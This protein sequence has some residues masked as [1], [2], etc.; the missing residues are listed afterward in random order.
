MKEF[1]FVIAHYTHSKLLL[2]RE[3][4]ALT[5]CFLVWIDNKS[6]MD[7]CIENLK[8]KV[9][10]K[11]QHHLWRINKQANKNDEYKY[12]VESTEEE[13]TPYNSNLQ[14]QGIKVSDREVAMT[15]K[16]QCP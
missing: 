15:M 9:L 3:R 12:T 2:S 8:G 11:P 10:E 7:P 4:A 5:Y 16:M 13:W 6:E 1:D 14:M